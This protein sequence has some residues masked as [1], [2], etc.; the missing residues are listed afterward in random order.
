MIRTLGGPFILVLCCT[1]GC[2]GASSVSGRVTLD[3]Q[4]LTTGTI[5]FKP[6]GDAPAA[7]GQ[8]SSNGSYRLSVGTSS[9]VAPG[10]Y[11]VTIVAT[12]LVAPTPTDPSPLPKMLT[13]EKYNDPATSGFTAEVKPGKN[14][15]PFEMKSEP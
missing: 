3:G 1:L 12:E 14:F 7:I 4:P 10:Q 11:Q 2:G 6:Q 5:T 8:I 15:F 9:S 13:P